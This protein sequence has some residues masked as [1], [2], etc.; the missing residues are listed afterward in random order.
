MS[1]SN[2]NN[3]SISVNRSSF[4]LIVFKAACP[5]NPGAERYHAGSSSCISSDLFRELLNISV[6]N[7]V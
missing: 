2:I 3:K 4:T 6:S 1:F 5:R 7:N